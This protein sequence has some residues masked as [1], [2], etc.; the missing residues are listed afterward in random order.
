MPHDELTARVTEAAEAEFMYAYE[1]GASADVV[2]EMGIA[3]GR[4]GGGVVLSMR[5]DVTGYWSKALGFGF[6]EPVTAD[7][8]DRVTGF[9]RAQDSQGAVIQI[10]PSVLPPDWDDICARHGLRPTAPWIKL[11]CSVDD[12]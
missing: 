9:F 7:L 6:D 10:A 5:H 4:V 2:A 8:V 3:T 12:F 11:G 1:S